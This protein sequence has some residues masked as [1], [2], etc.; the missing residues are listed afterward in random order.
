MY[1]VELHLSTMIKEKNSHESCIYTYTYTV[2]KLVYA[3]RSFVT[4][5]YI[6][7]EKKKQ[8][9]LLLSRYLKYGS[10]PSVNAVY[11]IV[12]GG[13]CFSI[14]CARCTATGII[15]IGHNNIYIYMLFRRQY[16]L[17]VRRPF[18][19]RLFQHTRRRED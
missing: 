15:H 7:N 18:R 13:F 6:T 9:R 1:A 8:N 10:R 16:N 4:R 5:E 2:Y 11:L 3:A 14:E 19:R 17:I 12:F